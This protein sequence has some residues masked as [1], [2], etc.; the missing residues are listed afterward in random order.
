MVLLGG[1]EG[2]GKVVCPGG[3][4]G[5]FFLGLG[6]ATRTAGGR[7]ALVSFATAA[8]AAALSR[9]LP[10]LLPPC[11]C[12][13]RCL[14]SSSSSSIHSDASRRGGP[15]PGVTSAALEDQKLPLAAQEP[16][17]PLER[18]ALGPLPLPPHHER[19]ELLPQEEG[20][21]LEGGAGSNGFAELLF[22]LLEVTAE[23]LFCGGGGG[24]AKGEVRSERKEKKE[25]ASGCQLAT[26]SEISL[27][28][29]KKSFFF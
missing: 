22:L 4:G 28:S 25:E 13:R 20:V 21:L 26:A 2:R 5:D 6:G 29:R 8:A 11:F 27:L 18:R 3:A 12:P 9:P 16:G 7:L 15:S 1:A 17:L 14:R 24:G 10:R 23:G 19:R